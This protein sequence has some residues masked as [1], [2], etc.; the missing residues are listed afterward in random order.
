MPVHITALPKDRLPE[1]AEA[2]AYYLVAEALTNV[3]KHAGATSATVRVISTGDQVRIEVRDD[4]VG[5][6]ELGSGF[7]LRGLADRVDA[8]G[9][10]LL[11]VSPHGAGTTLTGEIPLS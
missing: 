1:A 5:G 7:G 10:R 9:G 6:A 4:G 3:A 8:L 11:V 2:A